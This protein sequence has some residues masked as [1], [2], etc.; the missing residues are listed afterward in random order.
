MASSTAS[1]LLMLVL[2][3]KIQNQFLRSWQKLLLRDEKSLVRR[4]MVLELD[5]LAVRSLD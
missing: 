5:M 3:G 2:D 4:L 1:V